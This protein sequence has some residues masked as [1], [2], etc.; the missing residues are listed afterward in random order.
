MN[1]SNIEPLSSRK[2]RLAEP[3]A[4]TSASSWKWLYRIAGVAALISAVFIPIQVIVFV[5]WPPPLGGTV[6]D[7]FTLFQT[8]RL[9]GLIDLDLLLVA[10]NVLLVPIWLALYVALRR[11]G[12][13]IM[14]IAT[15]LGMIGIVLFIASN[16]AV[17]MLTLS[18]HYAAATTDAQR[19][20][21]LAAGQ[22]V[23]ASWQG[24]AFHVGYIV[25]SVAGI[26]I[27][28]VMLR[29][30]IFSKAIAYLGILANAIGLGLYLPGI[31]LFLAVFS[32]VFLEFWYILLARR[33][34]Q[35]GQGTVNE[36][37]N[38]PTR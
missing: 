34:F 30:T 37:A 36:A 14:A 18:D 35:L 21:F 5:A 6:S 38:R 19:A 17:E 3:H 13:S 33:F 15:A 7:W 24:T 28:A 11:A 27:P 9:V 2:Q 29:R 32:V 25:S 12:E 23:L 1:I 16:P 22:A 26:A 20:S 31:G 8:N 10:D 4:E